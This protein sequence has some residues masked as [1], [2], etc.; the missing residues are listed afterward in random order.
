MSQ[1]TEFYW[2]EEPE[3]HASRRK[4]IL[5]AHPEV[6]KLVGH[7][8]RSKYICTFLFVLPQMWLSVVT[9]NLPWIPY[10]AVAYVVGATITQALF[11]AIHELSHNLFFKSSLHNRAFSML[12]NLPIAIP[13]A[14]S[15]RH[16]HLEHHKFQ[17]V[18]GVD[19][20][21]PSRLEARLIRGPI[22]KAAW[23][24]C[25]ILTYAL[26]PCLI[27]PQNFTVLLFANWVVQIAFDAL[28][29][30]HFGTGPLVYMILCIFLA[31]G[32]HPC[33][34]HFISEHYIFPHLSSTQ[35]TYS[36]YGPLNWVTWNVGYHNEHHDFPYI[37]WSRLPKLKRAAPEFYDSLVVCDSWIGVI[38]DYV[39]R[40]DVGPY[41]R[42]KRRLCSGKK[43]A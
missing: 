36:Y 12:V 34:G 2:D 31:G 37:P 40:R 32:L 18:D 5:K 9:A 42:M 3:P 28:V 39:A 29:V 43:G 24:S 15:F 35:E 21:I 14:I 20:D 8:W 11:L 38:C 10:L 16:Y 6:G 27:K 17:G 19:A 23:A 30:S 26:R 25:Q 4:A 7:E 41:N 1:R 13:Y 33:A 22:A